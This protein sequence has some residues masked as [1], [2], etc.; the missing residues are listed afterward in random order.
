MFEKLETSLVQWI[1]FLF[2]TM[3]MLLMA[4]HTFGDLKMK[5]KEFDHLIKK[6]SFNFKSRMVQ[7]T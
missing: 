5:K 3:T 7:T 6:S 2:V 1:I 4:P